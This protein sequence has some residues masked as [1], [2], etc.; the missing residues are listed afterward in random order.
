MNKPS[1]SHGIPDAFL[2]LLC[3]KYKSDK[4]IVIF[5]DKN[6]V[7]KAEFVDACPITKQ[8]KIKMNN[9]DLGIIDALDVVGVE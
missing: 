9:G 3:A 6:I 7:Y 2:L 4:K 1:I 5:M 8:V